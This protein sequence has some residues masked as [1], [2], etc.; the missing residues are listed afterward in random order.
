MGIG[1]KNVIKH[2]FI[3]VMNEILKF[4]LTE[5]KNTNFFN[6]GYS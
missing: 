5:I 1:W 3:S 4:F 6:T 2:M